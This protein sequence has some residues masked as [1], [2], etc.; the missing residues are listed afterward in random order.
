MAIQDSPLWNPELNKGPK[1]KN[2][3]DV[4]ADWLKRNAAANPA[5]ATAPVKPAVSVSRIPFNPA[6][7]DIFKT[8]ANLVRAGTTTGTNALAEFTKRI[9][10][11]KGFNDTEAA[12]VG[13]DLA[14]TRAATGAANAD[15]VAQMQATIANLRAEK[16]RYKLDADTLLKDYETKTTAGI[17]GEKARQETALAEFIRN[18]KLSDFYAEQ[19]ANAGASA[20]G[21]TSGLG[22]SSMD[23]AYAA[24]RSYERRANAAN[25]VHALKQADYDRIRAQEAALVDRGFGIRYDQAGNIVDRGNAITGLQRDDI[26]RGRSWQDL[27]INQNR[28]DI[29][30]NS[31]LRERL[32]RSGASDAL[33]GYQAGQGM[34]R[35]AQGNLAALYA[36]DQAGALFPIDD[37][38]GQF[39]PARMPSTYRGRPDVGGG[40]GGGD[41][42]PERAVPSARPATVADRFTVN[43]WTPEQIFKAKGASQPP[44]WGNL[45]EA[46]KRAYL[47][48]VIAGG[49][50][51]GWTEPDENAGYRP[52]YSNDIPVMDFERYF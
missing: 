41:Y 22:G 10:D 13:A 15:A 29:L 28:G 36:N 25:D 16:D 5:A 9:N 39:T 19:D 8:N 40:G 2:Y 14:E 6:L 50:L 21:S 24:A 4:V 11:V 20:R 18:R 38:T 1:Y 35:D 7:E 42:F 3:G 32:L 51:S 26:V 48:Q 37:P 46:E 17:A 31:A 30:G 33:A 52:D 23:N 27:A 49:D 47:Q 45:S 44:F 43:G 34:I 12:K